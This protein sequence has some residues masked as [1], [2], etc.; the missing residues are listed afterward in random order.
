[1]QRDNEQL[2]PNANILLLERLIV[3]EKLST[4][5]RQT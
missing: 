2:G 1:M 3:V 5:M 4:L